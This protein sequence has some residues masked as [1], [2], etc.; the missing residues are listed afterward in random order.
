MTGDW[1]H[2]TSRLGGTVADIYIYIFRGFAHA[3]D[4][5]NQ[6]NPIEIIK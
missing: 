6:S 2:S 4:P 3:A 5:Y 1:R